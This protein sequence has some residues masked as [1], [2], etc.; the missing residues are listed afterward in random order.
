M[1][2]VGIAGPARAGKDTAADYLTK[3]YGLV[4][5]SFA[6]PLK[7]MLEVGIGLSQAQL[8]GDQKE[9][10]DPVYGVTPRYMAQTIGT[11]WG[12]NLIHPDLWVLAMGRLMEQSFTE[13][14]YHPGFVIPDVRFEN[15]AEFIRSRGFLLHVRRDDPDQIDNPGHTSE[16][17]VAVCE[18]DL[19]IENNDTLEYLYSQL[20][21]LLV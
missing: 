5:T 12:R 16:S 4:K 8:Y 15:E 18:G 14:T 2:L 13:D 9:V 10:I 1:R 19:V 17:G 21:W 6:D 20:E 7:K 3:H 11:E